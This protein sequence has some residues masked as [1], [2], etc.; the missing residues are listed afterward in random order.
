MPAFSFVQ[1]VIQ[2][3][4]DDLRSD[5]QA[6]A[7]LFNPDGSPLFSV[8][9]KDFLVDGWGNWTFHTVET[10]INPPPT[11]IGGVRINLIQGSSAFN[12]FGTA[13]NWDIAR[14]NVNLLNRA[15]DGSIAN[16]ACQLN[17]IGNSELQDGSIGLVRL[18]QNAD[19]S[20]DGPASPIY[21][22]GPNSGC[23]PE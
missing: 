8:V 2:T 19:S 20:G 14:L 5:S 6:T 13:D 18:S 22:T 4:N 16:E 9:L 17:L 3:G 12:P 15:S 11:A 10:P 7:D 23:P 1:F 21:W